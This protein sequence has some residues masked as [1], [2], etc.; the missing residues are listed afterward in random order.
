LPAGTTAVPI[1]FGLSGLTANT[2]YYFRAAASNSG[3]TAK[4]D[5][6]NFNSAIP[7]AQLTLAG[8]GTGSGRVISSPTGLDCTI[9]KGTAGGAG[10]SAT[11]SGGTVVTLNL[12]LWTGSTVTAWSGTGSSC[13]GISCQVTMDQTRSITLGLG[14]RAGDL[15]GDGLVDQ[16]D[17]DQLLAGWGRTDKPPAD[18]NRDGIVDAVDLSILLSNWTG[19]LTVATAAASAVTGTSATLNGSVT[20]GG[21]AATAWFEWGTSA[22]LAT[23]TTTA[24]QSLPAGTTA[25]LITFGLSGLTANTTYYFRAAA[26]NSGGTAKGDILTFTTG[27]Q[28]AASTLEVLDASPAIGDDGTIYVAALEPGVFGNG[29]LYAIRPDATEKW[30]F[31][32][33]GS[34]SVAITSDGA[35]VLGGQNENLY[36]VDP[37]SGRERCHALV[38]GTPSSPAIA[39]DG[40]IYVATSSAVGTNNVYALRQ[41]CTEKWHIGRFSLGG[42]FVASPSV[43]PDGTIY[44]GSVAT[45][46]FYA[47][48]P[49]DGSEKWN[50]NAGTG[51]WSSAAIGLDGTVYVGAGSALYALS[52]VNGQRK[53]SFATSGQVNSSPA[54]ATDGTTYVG[55]NNGVLYAVSAAGTEL[56]HL[57]VPSQG[58]RSSPAVGADGVVYFKSTLRQVFAVGSAGSIQWIVNTEGTSFSDVQSSPALSTGGRLYVGSGNL[59]YA[60]ATA[61]PGLALTSWPKFHRDN[62][63]T[64][65][66]R[67]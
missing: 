5:I 9:G 56:W 33:G 66:W 60:I 11:L 57:Q 64:G 45:N 50:F 62:R 30:V 7:P 24:T 61:S 65:G 51:V 36:V 22:T 37:L 29:H 23:F 21:K 26:S 14:G 28:F 59:L 35:I 52:P 38:S 34:A 43:G 40:T 3:G 42:G 15:N 58:I 27:W 8:A 13:S 1:T 18:I 6:L 31:P 47:I 44:V 54:I 39:T 55:T 19:G 46:L 41:D 48:N 12:T 20:P 32:V 16:I 10:C 17:L 2:T 4:G 67:P 49:A 25:V 63:N 53:W